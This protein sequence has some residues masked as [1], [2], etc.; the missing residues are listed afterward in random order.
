MK[1][2]LTW[3]TSIIFFIELLDTTLLY[4]CAVPVADD[5]KI[6][7]V[8]MSLPIISYIIGTCIF[9][10]LSAW[11]SN[12][13]NRINSII[14]LLI[15][16]SLF[17]IACSMSPEIYIFSLFRFFQGVT[18]SICAAIA[19]ITLLSICANNEIV[20][21][22]GTINILALVGTAIGPFIGALFSHYISWRIAFVMN[23][24]VCLL[25]VKL[26]M[27]LRSSAYFS[28]PFS[29]NNLDG[30]GF[31]F[32]STFLIMISI[33]LEQVS[34]TLNTTSFLIIAIGTLFGIAYV[35]LWQTRQQSLLSKKNSILELHAFKNKDFLF[36]TLINIIARSAMCG[37]PLLMSITLQQLYHFSVITAGLYLAIIASAAI[38]AKFMSPFI[39][40]F[41]VRKSVILFV[42]LSAISIM[43]LSPLDFL[44]TKH[45]LWIACVLFGFATSLLYTAMNSV[46]YLTIKNNEIPNASN[47]GIIIQQFAIG[48][49]VVISVGGLQ[50][51]LALHGIQLIPDNRD[52]IIKI[53]HILCHF[54]A[55]LMMLNL[56]V[57]LL[58][59]RYHKNYFFLEEALGSIYNSFPQAKKEGVE[60]KSSQ[61]RGE[62]QV[63]FDENLR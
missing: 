53:Y 15:A 42:M 14:I 18:I 36:G 50:L 60:T 51:L 48:L 5:F 31:I 56:I 47:I 39:N 12:K 25:I 6:T 27:P 49:G 9:I 19:I 23:L 54:L 35:A 41:G 1:K 22:M 17:S 55:I 10:P 61:I 38:I 40:Q 26:L 20:T 13:Y 63:I 52:Q 21:T 43:L 7:P 2:R 8:R 34:H 44:L 11:L 29:E 57:A 62:Y 32:I 58:F 33:G 4:S 24:P 30:W 59:K 3:M 16:F 28:H 37:L 46:M 45:L